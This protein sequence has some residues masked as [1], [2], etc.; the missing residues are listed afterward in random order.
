MRL[1]FLK[2]EKSVEI[3]H[4][5]RILDD[6]PETVSSD[7]QQLEIYNNEYTEIIYSNGNT[8]EMNESPSYVHE[9]ILSWENSNN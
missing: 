2:E 4:E 6:I 8:E 1:T 3:N 5:K 9:L 7:I